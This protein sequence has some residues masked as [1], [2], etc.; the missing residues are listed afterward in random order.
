[1][2]V[3]HV[4]KLY[5][6]DRGGGIVAAKSIIEGLNGRVSP[7]VLTSVLRG[8]GRRDKHGSAEIRR[9]SSI[10]YLNSMPIAPTLPMWFH[11]DARRVDIVHVHLPF[12]LADIALSLKRTRAAVVLHWHSEIVQQRWAKRFVRPFLARALQRADKII[13]GSRR[14]LDNCVDLNAFRHKCEVIPYGIDLVYWRNLD[15]PLQ[16]RIDALK[17]QYPNMLLFV[18]RLV[19]YKGLRYLIEAMKSADGEL[20][21]AGDGPLR[22]QLQDKV[23]RYGLQERVHFFGDIDDKELKALF[24]ACQIFV[25]PSIW[26]NEAFGLT[27][28]E[29]MA[30]GKAIINTD[31][32]TGVPWAARH[33]KEALTVRAGDAP[34]LAGAINALLSE[35]EQRIRLGQN[36]LDRARAKF[37]LQFTNEKIYDLYRRLVESK[38]EFA[39]DIRLERILRQNET[40]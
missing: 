4:Y 1:M 36:G 40:P 17:K 32:P 19:E 22:S 15:P 29:A 39:R 9:V 37:N 27:Q 25:L 8:S 10:G 31:L 16:R 3:L 30:C 26:S 20:V 18:G 5:A 13:V 6:P 7:S 33:G 34:M 2:R 38:T 21:I 24:H 12:P 11:V 28:L 14:H 23:R 35:P